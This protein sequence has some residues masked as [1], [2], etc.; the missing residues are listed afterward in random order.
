MYLFFSSLYHVIAYGRH[1]VWNGLG[2][3]KTFFGKTFS[4]L[5]LFFISILIPF[6]NMA[7]TLG[8]PLIQLK[9]V[10]QTWSCVYVLRK[11]MTERTANLL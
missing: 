6:F 9:M 5:V 10:I 2:A 7:P 1:N 4:T 11:D 8:I 3:T